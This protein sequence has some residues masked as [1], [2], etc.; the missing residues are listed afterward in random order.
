MSHLASVIPRQSIDSVVKI[1]HLCHWTR[2]YSVPQG[3]VHC[4]SAGASTSTFVSSVVSAH[5]LISK[6]PAPSPPPSF[7]PNSITTT[8]YIIISPTHSYPDF[9]TSK[10]LS[11][12]QLLK[13]PSSLISL[14]LSNLS[15]G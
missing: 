9:N 5:S 8:H 6:Q 2:S 12:V 7:T 13:L 11:L 4:C 15:T 14:L 1:S 3:S 10:T